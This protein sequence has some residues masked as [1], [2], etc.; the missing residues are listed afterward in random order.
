[1]EVMARD[2][3][4]LLVTD[5]VAVTALPLTIHRYRSH[6]NHMQMKRQPIKNFH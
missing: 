3:S 5:S 1:M 6:A 4:V 2:W